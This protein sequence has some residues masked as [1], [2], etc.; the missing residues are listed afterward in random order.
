[1]GR[2]CFAA[3]SINIYMISNNVSEKWRQREKSEV[4]ARVSA[5]SESPKV[6]CS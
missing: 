5:H 6:Q 3:T 2:K 1:M 4:P